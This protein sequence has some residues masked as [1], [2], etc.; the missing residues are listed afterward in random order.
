VLST[1]RDMGDNNGV[2]RD[3]TAAV[4]GAI[5]IDQYGNPSKDVTRTT[6]E[7]CPDMKEFFN[8]GTDSGYV[9]VIFTPPAIEWANTHIT[10]AQV[11]TLHGSP[12]KVMKYQLDPNGVIRS[13]PDDTVS[14]IA[15]DLAIQNTFPAFQQ[16]SSFRRSTLMSVR[17]FLPSRP[18]AT[19]DGLLVNPNL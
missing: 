3:H 6:L 8:L 2:D 16:M 11:P 5:D 15:Q 14:V 17:N 12:L 9:P 13:I 1:I 4:C 10:I 18:V 7:P 19:T